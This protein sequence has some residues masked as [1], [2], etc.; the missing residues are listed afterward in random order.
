MSFLTTTIGLMQATAMRHD[1]S[2]A[3]QNASQ[4]MMNLA[5]GSKTN[6]I[7]NNMSLEQAYQPSPQFGGMS[8]MQYLQQQD[9]NFALTK[10]RADIN[11]MVANQ[12]YENYTSDSAKKD[13][14]NSFKTFA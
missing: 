2:A 9:K 7:V 12:L 3:S 6:D 5:F 14:Q 10:A 1:A 8:A 4:N 13:I 11:M